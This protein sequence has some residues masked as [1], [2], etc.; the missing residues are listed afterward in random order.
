MGS[1][2]HGSTGT[3][4]TTPETA[5]NAY[6]DIVRHWSGWWPETTCGYKS[7]Q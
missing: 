1:A 2:E 3:R 7:L 5:G 4:R 6:R